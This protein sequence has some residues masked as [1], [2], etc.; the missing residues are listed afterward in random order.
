MVPIRWSDSALTRIHFED[1][2]ICRL[3]QLAD[4]AA[5]FLNRSQQVAHS[6]S[7]TVH[8]EELIDILGTGWNFV[9]IDYESRP[10][11]HPV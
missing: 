7:R 6:K 8:D 3:I 10:R 2:K 5:Y 11:R 1:S 4:F 9:N